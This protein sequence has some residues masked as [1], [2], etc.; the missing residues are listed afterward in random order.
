[1]PRRAVDL[2][3]VRELAER[4]AVVETA[5]LVAVLGAAR[6]LSFARYGPIGSAAWHVLHAA[7]LE[8][9]RRLERKSRGLA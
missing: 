1:M 4:L 6:R 5:R 8:A 7:R 2:E 9:S 3:A